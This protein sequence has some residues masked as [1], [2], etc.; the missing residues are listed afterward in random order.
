MYRVSW[1]A[2]IRSTSLRRDSSETRIAFVFLKRRKL[3]HIFNPSNLVRTWRFKSFLLTVSAKMSSTNV[4]ASKTR[5]KIENVRLSSARFIA[6]NPITGKVSFW[7]HFVL[8]DFNTH[9]R[10]ERR[11]SERKKFTKMK[12]T[13]LDKSLGFVVCFGWIEVKVL[14]EKTFWLFWCFNKNKRWAKKS[15]FRC[16]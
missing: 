15:K 12:L 1:I 7:V 8:I 3:L 14:F 9:S 16:L 10:R 6:E 5:L 13:F 11:G 2:H 4:D